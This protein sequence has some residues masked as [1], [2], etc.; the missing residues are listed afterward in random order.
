MDPHGSFPRFLK[1]DLKS[2]IGSAWVR[3]C[4]LEDLNLYFSR[5]FTES[6]EFFGVFSDRLMLYYWEWFDHVD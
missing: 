6:M 4:V 3:K 5:E 1:Y 2:K